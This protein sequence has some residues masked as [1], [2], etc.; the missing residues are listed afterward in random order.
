MGLHGQGV[1]RVLDPPPGPPIPPSLALAHFHAHG[2]GHAR[3][4][5]VKEP[6][7]E[8]LCRGKKIYE[9][10]RFMSVNTAIEQL[11]EIEERRGEGVCLPD[12]KAIGVARVGADDQRILAGTLAELVDQDFGPPLHSLILAGELHHV[13][14]EAWQR[15]HVSSQRS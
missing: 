10:P 9:P 3:S 7:L 11:L 2:H 6:S 14:L 8:A 15:H 13:E 5:Q 1:G 12:S 4:R